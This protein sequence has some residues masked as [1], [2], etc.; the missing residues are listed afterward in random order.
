M[1]YL[2]WVGLMPSLLIVGVLEGLF[3]PLLSEAAPASSPPTIT[4]QLDSGTV[5]TITTAL[6]S[7]CDATYN[8]CY[9][10][11]TGRVVTGTNGRQ[12]RLD[13]NGTPRVRIADKNGLDKMS[14][15]GF[16]LVPVGSWS[17]TEVHTLTL[18]VRHTFNAT[19]DGPT[20]ATIN[21]TNAGLTTWALRSA[22]EFN[23]ISG[24][25][26]VNNRVT[27]TGTGIFSGT[28][29]VNILST[30]GTKNRN[31]LTFT[32]TGPAAVADINWG[33]LNNLDMG[34]EDPSYPQFNCASSQ[35]TS[36]CRPTVTQ[37][38][39]ATI[40]GPDTLKVLSGPLDVFGA[41]CSLTFGAE[42]LKHAKLIKYAVAVFKV[43]L[44]HIRTSDLREK[45]S[46]L[47]SYL[48][49]ILAT[50]TAPPSDPNCPGANVV[51]F[52]S[53]LEAAVDGLVIISDGSRPGVA[54]PPH[55]Y[56]V[57][58]E[59][60]LTWEQA[61]DAAQGLGIGGNVC[62]LATITS[63]AEQ[64][65]I[66]GLLPDPSEFPAEPAQQYWIGGFQTS[67]SSEP[68]GGWQWIN[69][70]G[71]FWNNAPVTDMFANWGN[72]SP[73]GLQPDNVCND[74]G[75]QNHLSLDHRYGWGWDD[76]DQFLNGVIRGYVTEGTSG[77]CVPPVI[78]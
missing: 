16:K 19:T 33:G 37:K 1:N 27:L 20:G 38:L 43:V 58:N 57:I 7:T 73:P 74:S 52:H 31:P 11:P 17:N 77:L 69:G 23:A 48:E 15:T 71:M 46:D 70:E 8:Y 34:M 6:S 21:Q 5:Q 75:C 29:S 22:G 50:T 54:A 14:P 40:N 3:A 41:S 42:E 76:N 36:A 12:Y 4:L 62:D 55:Y 2:R 78:D 53:A 59:P 13:A 44:P 9:S 72:S 35:N 63:A 32:I 47:I 68:G 24:S 28:T 25:D 65:I 45:I 61:R 30:S 39:V 26:P 51:A 49:R 60:G 10:I 56:A 67:E 64:A 66:T 18:T